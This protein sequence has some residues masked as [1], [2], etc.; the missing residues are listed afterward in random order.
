MIPADDVVM[1]DRRPSG[2]HHREVRRGELDA[3]ASLGILPNNGFFAPE[4][5]VEYFAGSRGSG[6]CHQL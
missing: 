6:T 1:S 5:W 3:S 2:S 4:A